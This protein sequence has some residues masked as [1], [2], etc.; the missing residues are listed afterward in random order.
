MQV[1]FEHWLSVSYAKIGVDPT[2]I[3]EYLCAILH[4]A[5]DVGGNYQFCHGAAH[6]QREW[7]SQYPNSL[8]T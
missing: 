2:N 5:L 8:F 7:L 6:R 3:P 1:G 4:G